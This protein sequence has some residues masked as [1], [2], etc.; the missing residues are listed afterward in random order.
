MNG[1]NW[2]DK[3]KFNENLQF[4][5]S[6]ELFQIGDYKCK[7][8]VSKQT[9]GKKF[10]V[11]FNPDIVIVNKQFNNALSQIPG[12]AV[13]IELQSGEMNYKYMLSKMNFDLVSGSKFEV[14][15]T[16]YRVMTYEEG[17]KMN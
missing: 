17:Q 3:N 12:I 15:K 9:E 4:D 11:Y 8:A 14:P 13:K 1:A 6:D 10:T 5:I 7:K 16:G 2:K